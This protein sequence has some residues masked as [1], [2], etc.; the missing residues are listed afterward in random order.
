MVTRHLL[1]T[2]PPALVLALMTQCLE[3]I[4]PV[5]DYIESQFKKITTFESMNEAE[6]VNLL[7]GNGGSQVDVVLYV[8]SN[9]KCGLLVYPAGSNK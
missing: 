4:T 7:S 2:S 3:C 9:S 1:V 8:I 6:M 5:I